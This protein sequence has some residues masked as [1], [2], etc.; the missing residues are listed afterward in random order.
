MR[1]AFSR[2]FA[3][4]TR[5]STKKA[6]DYVE[7]VK[8]RMLETIRGTIADWVRAGSAVALPVPAEYEALLTRFAVI[9]TRRYRSIAGGTRAAVQTRTRTKIIVAS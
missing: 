8:A 5:I 9:L 6:A 1:P 3:S 4:A 7:R 2:A